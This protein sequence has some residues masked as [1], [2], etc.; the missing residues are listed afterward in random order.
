MNRG[1]GKMINRRTRNNY[2]ENGISELFP[3]ELGS[4]KQWVMIRGENKNNPILLFL[5]GGP[6]TANIG[7][8]A[9][10]QKLLE[11]SFVVVNW[12][13]LGGGLS[14][15]KTIPKEALTVSK[16]VEYTNELIQYLLQ[17]F[18]KRKLYLVGHSWGS[19]IGILV[20]Q[21]YPEIIEKYIG[22]SQVVDGKLN[23][24]YAYEY[25]LKC[26]ARENDKKAIEQLKSIGEPPYSDWMKGLQIRSNWSNKFGAAIKNGSLA[27]VYMG[28]M[29]KGTEYKLIDIF[30]FMSGFTLSLK[31]LWPE[32]MEINLFERVEGLKVPAYFFLGRNDYQAPSCI[33][34]MYVK[35]LKAETKEIVWFEESAHM[36]NIEE[37]EK[38]A[39]EMKRLVSL[40]A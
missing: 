17:R 5:H 12:D 26:A 16:M 18:Q 25:C 6:G 30:K 34:E 15:N 8:A 9:D 1:G 4:Y 29:L 11:K 33:A 21:K 27:Q 14:Y 19:L 3:V 23:E 22:V 2:T 20:A 24:K 10:T 31:Y 13:Q 39:S 37:E 32:V 35:A 28:K 38:F 36:C 7:V 40:D